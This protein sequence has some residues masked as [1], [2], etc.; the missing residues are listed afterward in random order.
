MSLKPWREVIAP[1][2]DVLEGTFQQSEFAADITAVHNGNASH[3]Y[4]D[5]SA[6]F[7][8]TYIT[9]GMRHLLTSVA[10]RL[11]SKGGDP[12]IQL[13]TAFGGGK[14]HT[15]LAVYHMATRQGSLSDLAGI[16]GLLDQAK[17][18]DVPRARVAVIDGNSLSPG[19]PWKRGKQTIKTLWGELAWQLGGAD[20]YKLVQ[21]ADK[22][23]TSPGKEILKTLME[24]H[25][26][27]VILIDELVA[28]IRQFTGSDALSGG[29]YDS[30]LSFIQSLTEATKLVPNAIVLASLPESEIEA[31][32]QRGVAALRALEKTFGRIQALWK[33]VAT[34]EAFEIVRRRLFDN[35]ADEKTRDA[36]C[37]AFADLYIAEGAKMP[38]E[39]QESHYYDRLVQA[40]PI[41]P[42][43]FDRLYEDWT[44]LEGFQRT[45]GV[46]KLMAKVI[47]RLWKDQNSDQMIMPGSL[48]L[49]DSD[50]RNELVYYLNAGWDA[51]LE[52][53]ID[54]ERAE[55][56]ALDTKETRFGQQQATRRVARSLFL[57][58]AP[59][60]GGTKEGVRGIDRARVLI[61]CLQP[62]QSAALFS[63][64]LNRLADRLHYLNSSGDKTLDTTRFWF[65]TRA[66]LRREMEDRKGRF[67]DTNE[68]L[69]KI[70]T[71][72]K[73]VTASATFFDGI[74]IFTPHSDVP[75]DTALRL[76]V[77]PPDK[78][79]QREDAKTAFKEVE[80]FIRNNGTKPRYRSNRLLFV[81]PDWSMLSRLHDCTCTVLA[82][83]SIVDDVKEGRLNIDR[84]Q[85][86]QAKKELQTA[87]DVLSRVV[88]ECYKWLL[89]PVMTTPTD[90]EIQIESFA[91]SASGNGFGAEVERICDEN[92]LVI[93]LWSPI[94]LRSNLQKLYWK[95]DRP[96]VSAM[97]F[98]EDS[99]R[100]LYLPRLKD[101]HVLEQAII[102]GAE[103]KDFFG[104]AYGESNGKFDGFKF[105]DNYIQLD[106][107]L[108]L[109]DPEV[110]HAYE[111]RLAEEAA[112]AQEKAIP[113]SH[114]KSTSNTTAV[115]ENNTS[116]TGLQIGS[117][118]NAKAIQSNHFYGSI[119]IVPSTAKRDLVQ[120]A[121]EIISLLASDPR[122]TLKVTVEISADFPEGVSDQIK[123]AV[124]E[125]ATSLE[126]GTK[127]WE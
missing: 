81:A 2:A 28:Y 8:R 108:L 23:G 94:H 20:G 111:T 104:T 36:V 82:W 67:R 89:C 63:D 26:P 112:K 14:T 59:S 45:R 53:D 34:E 32:S 24:N 5:A 47:Y 13:Q 121:D 91:I 105:G 115:G 88:R 4:Q 117:E 7:D 100:Y 72:V 11:N 85:E 113:P 90:N 10:N 87:E 80:E 110:S 1:H 17:L 102:K 77:L 39:T 103:S 35:V 30:N 44:T 62:G 41:H 74:H 97:T 58:S 27:C 18:M 106:D 40:Y 49:Y 57:G 22:N 71:V 61:G 78:Y 101:R 66:N 75:D 69:G 84:L 50:S 25:A 119:E 55:T 93:S 124:S 73:K 6:F 68:L 107:T 116:G 122:A 33:P 19:Q 21:E 125:N 31:G 16:P 12:V 99:Q 15:M 43:V 46:L 60:A 126:F 76:V 3:E 92:E 70:A 123:R 95:N 127:T 114:G 118:G 54:G 96:F 86:N 51:V 37:R 48:P 79:Y 64:A 65:D 29:T 109:I 120:V 83:N 38:S 52:K 42:E 56:T 9:E 98:W